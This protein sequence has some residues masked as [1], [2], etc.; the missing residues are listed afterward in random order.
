M[1]VIPKNY[2]LSSAFAQDMVA[3]KKDLTLQGLN[4]ESSLMWRSKPT[5]LRTWLQRWNRVNWLQRLF[6]RILKPSHHKSFETKLA[7]S[8]EDIRV[9]HFQQQGKEKER[10]TQDIFG[11]IYGDTSEQLDLFNVFSKTSKDTYLLD[12]DQLS[13]IWDQMVTERR[14]EY[15]QRLKLAQHI[16]EKEFLFWLTPTTSDCKNMDTAN[17]MMLTKQVKLWPTPCARDCR[18]DG[19]MAAAQNRHSPSISAMVR[20]FP[21][22]EEVNPTIGKVHDLNPDWVEQMMG[23]PLKLTDLGCWATE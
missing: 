1:W 9:S 12:S 19:D 23:L 10:T 5:P 20:C 3:S 22:E 15:S 21:Q 11:H 16:R 17:Q 14:G 4:I 18:D 13:A 2:Q 8:M 6:T 7:L